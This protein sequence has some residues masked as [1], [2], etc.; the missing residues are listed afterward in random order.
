MGRKRLA[1]IKLPIANADYQ[2]SSSIAF[3]LIE[4]LV[5]VSIMGILSVIAG[6]ILIN[7][8]RA[9]NKA[10]AINMLERTGNEVL[11]AMSNEIRNAV[12]ISQISGGVRATFKDGR[13]VDFAYV[14]PTGSRNGY[15][16]RNGEAVTSNSWISGVNVA[17]CTFAVNTASNPPIVR[18]T[19]RLEEALGASTRRDYEASVNLTTSVALRNY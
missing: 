15:I 11:S 18:V 8:T 10:R 5:V 7:V 19:I 9:Y 4:L 13:T 17:S 6:N 3:T 1:A 12:S 2:H 14:A 16:T